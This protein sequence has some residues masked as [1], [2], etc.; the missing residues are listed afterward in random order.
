MKVR[1]TR[2]AK[3]DIQVIYFYTIDNFGDEQA[4][5]YLGGLDDTFDLLTDS[6][7]RPRL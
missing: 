2:R 6:S 3:A 1:L 7:E 5:V 4:G